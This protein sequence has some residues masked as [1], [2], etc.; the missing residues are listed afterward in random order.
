VAQIVTMQAEYCLDA[1]IRQVHLQP[2]KV[3]FRTLSADI[4]ALVAEPHRAPWPTLHRTDT[5]DD[6]QP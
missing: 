1:L 5:E 6:W 4:G 3:T 2:H